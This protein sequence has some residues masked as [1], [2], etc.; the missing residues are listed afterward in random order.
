MLGCKSGTSSVEDA[1]LTSNVTGAMTSGL[2]VTDAV[3]VNSS[4]CSSK[5]RSWLGTCA[6]TDDSRAL[7]T[8]GLN[9]NAGL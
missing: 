4:P 6:N 2:F 3:T 7:F 9:V 5:W 8:T 1:V